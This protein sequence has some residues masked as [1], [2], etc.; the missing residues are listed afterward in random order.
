MTR[1]RGTEQRDMEIYHI[2]Q[3]LLLL[4]LE[5]AEYDE[6]NTPQLKIKVQKI[7]KLCQQIDHFGHTWAKI[8][9]N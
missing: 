1:S 6:T 5:Y 8:G 9:E 4:I 7:E 2:M 3:N